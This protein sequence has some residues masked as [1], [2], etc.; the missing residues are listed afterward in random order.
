MDF[1]TSMDISSSALS[2]QR[3][4]M[5]VISSN[6]ANVN[7]TRTEEGGPYKKK[8]V[9]F[10]A[11]NVDNFQ[12]VL[13]NNIDKNLHKVEVEQVVEDKGPGKLIY[14]P[15]HPDA[16]RDGY[17]EMPNISLVSEMVDMLN[18]TRAY[19]A[20]ISV[21]NTAKS[22]ANKALSLAQ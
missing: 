16:N 15:A 7:T 6:L 8:S 11:A 13:L 2:A 20:N 18:T 4:R 21:M 3:E 10:K 22:M 1:L 17:V 9:V 5:N 14:D 12:K 19:E